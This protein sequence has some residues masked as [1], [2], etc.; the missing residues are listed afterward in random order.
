MKLL[1]V[2]ALAQRIISLSPSVTE[3][4]HGIDAFDRL[5]AVSNYCEYPPETQAMPR[6]GGWGS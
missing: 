4:L 3:I 1:V 5:V 2:L 6:V